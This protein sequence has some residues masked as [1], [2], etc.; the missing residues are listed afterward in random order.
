VFCALK[1]RKKA[2]LAFLYGAAGALLRIADELK[3][4][5]CL[6]EL[7]LLFLRMGLART[8]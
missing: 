5:M 7:L 3:V 1:M 8:V 6:Q 2:C 4:K